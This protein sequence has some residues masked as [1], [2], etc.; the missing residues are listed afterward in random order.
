MSTVRY[1][2]GIL[3]DSENA[4][5]RFRRKVRLPVT[6][7]VLYKNQQ[8]VMKAHPLVGGQAPFCFYFVI[9]MCR[10]SPL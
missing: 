1:L 8:I 2:D 9:A 6:S 7:T 3:A 10:Y 5:A 4:Q